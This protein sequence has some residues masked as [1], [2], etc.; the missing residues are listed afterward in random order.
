MF[1]DQVQVTLFRREEHQVLRPCHGYIKSSFS[2]Q[3]SKPFPLMRL[4]IKFFQVVDVNV[5]NGRVHH[6]F[7]I[8]IAGSLGYEA[9]VRDYDLIFGKEKHILFLCLIIINVVSPENPVQNESEVFAD[10]FV[11][12]IK[13]TFPYCFRC[14]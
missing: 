3:P 7:C 12:I 13:L 1:L 9:F 14:Q 2:Y 8:V 10:I 11:L 5:Q 6:R 4:L